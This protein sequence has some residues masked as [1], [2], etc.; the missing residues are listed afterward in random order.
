MIIDRI[1]KET[2]KEYA[3]RRNEAKL[4]QEVRKE[5]VY[6][7]LPQIKQID[8]KI[9]M[10]GILTV[11]K[12]MKRSVNA[13]ILKDCPNEY[14]C[15]SKEEIDNEILL[16]KQ[17]KVVILKEAGYPGDYMENAFFCRKCSDTGFV[18]NNGIEISCECRRKL[19]SEKLKAV[20]GVPAE[21]V[22]S[23]FDSSLYSETANQ[24]K[25][26]ISVSPKVQMEAVYKRCVRFAEE[27]ENPSV[28]NMVFLGN[29]GLGKTFLGN[30]II[31]ALTDK[32]VS[33]LYM[34][35]TSLFKPF[36]PGF[37]S[38]EEANELIDF[39]FNCKF[40]LIDDL[41]SE[42]Q[43][44]TR[45]AELLE[46]L[47]MR[48]LRGKKELCKTVITTNLSP[49]NLFAHYGERVASRI[50]GGYD[51]LKFAGDDIRLKLKNM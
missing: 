32:G 51:I 18:L 14:F 19:L 33:C 35:S 23:K 25:Y 2:E 27:F 9:N 16:L 1:H 40:L 37:Y 38:Q 15:Y 29:S 7:E 5:R 20:S 41:G 4:A 39:I 21:D 49:A 26:G 43:T 34:P 8:K 17:K 3:Q 48:E 45:Y 13:N 24:E 12:A 46:I 47:N 36:A 10:L 28:N 50:L 31:N 30:C 22:F 44:G 11:Y 42:K 6:T